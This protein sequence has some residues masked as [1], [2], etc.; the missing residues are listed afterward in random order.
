M[1]RALFGAATV[2]ALVPAGA[3]AQDTS[4]LPGAEQYVLRAQYGEFRPSIAGKTQKGGSAGEGT[5]IDLEDDLAVENERTFEIKGALQLKKGRKIRGSYTRLDYDGDQEADRSFSYGNTR[6]L[7]F[8]R[9]ITSIKGAYYTADL[10]W[11]FY[12]G[13]RGFVGVLLGAK[14]FDI[15]AVLVSPTQGV[16]EVD[17]IR[18]PIPVLGIATRLYYGKLSF[19]GEASGLTAGDRGT[20]YDIQTSL[21]FHV[22]D[23]LA[24]MGGYRHLSL[25]GKDG[26]DQVKLQLG[27][28]QFGLEI[29]L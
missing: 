28:W 8:E 15:D 25:D 2:L 5:L 13:Q 7:R 18:A 17:T 16:R 19:E 20:L 3:W 11:D 27:G 21:R 9:V 6:F 29:S 10:E 12:K 24:A 23:R 14:V 26:D 1:S 22:S 4:G